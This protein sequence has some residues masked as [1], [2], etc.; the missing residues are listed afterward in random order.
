MKNKAIILG[1]TL[2]LFGWVLAACGEKSEQVG[3]REVIERE[4]DKIEFSSWIRDSFT[5]SPDNQHIAYVARRGNKVV[6]MVDG[7]AGKEYD[8]IGTAPIFSPDSQRLA[9]G[10]GRGRKWIVVVD[11]REGKEYDGIM[12]GDPVF[13]PDSEHVAYRAARGNKRLVIVDGE[14]GKEYDDIVAIGGAKL[15]WDDDNKLHYLAKKGDTIILV[16]EEL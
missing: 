9:Y 6:V 12:E 16:E 10:A 8:G 2:F 14:E 11:G 3:G 1:L 13:S 5:V 7:K 4:L 15:A